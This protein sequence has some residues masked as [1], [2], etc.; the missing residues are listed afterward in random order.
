MQKVSVAFFLLLASVLWGERI[1]TNEPL[2]MKDKYQIGE[3]LKNFVTAVNDKNYKLIATFVSDTEPNLVKEIQDKMSD[4]NSYAL[5]Y[6]LS[7]AETTPDGNVKIIGKYKAAGV[8]W[9]VEGFSTYFV[10]KNMNGDWILV[11][12]DFYKG[13]SFWGLIPFFL[14]FL[15]L[16][17]FWLWM[18]IDCARSDDQKRVKWILLL[19][20]LNII[21]AVFYF[22]LVKRK[23]QA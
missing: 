5:G 12:T 18:L 6:S 22:F 7:E 17:S 10:F 23:R 2:S 4:T 11:D 20:F 15:A 3:K 13:F 16:F 9:K 14:F 1:T 8:G 19:V 21:G